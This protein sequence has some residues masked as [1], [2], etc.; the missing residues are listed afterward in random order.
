MRVCFSLLLIASVLPAHSQIA[1]ST[2]AHGSVAKAVLAQEAAIYEQISTTATYQTDGTGDFENATRVRLQSSAGVQQFG[3]LSFPYQKSF[4]E[5]TI[6]YVRVRKPDGSVISTSLD[7]V[8]D[9]EAEVTREA[10]FYS[11]LREK[12]IAV[13]GLA[14]GDVLEWTSKTR[15]F[16]ALAPNHFW[17]DYNFRKDVIVRDEQL[18]LEVPKDMYVKVKSRE[19]QPQINSENGQKIYVWK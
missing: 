13:K 18:R 6:G 5:I 19:P 12:H 14:V 10:P 8:Q 2:E 1:P 3:L 4:Q 15:I 9:I 17:L 7:D 16:K 11:D